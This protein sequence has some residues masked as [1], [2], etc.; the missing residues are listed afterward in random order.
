[1]TSSTKDAWCTQSTLFT[2]ETA[3][4]LVLTVLPKSEEACD[5][6]EPYE[7]VWPVRHTCGTVKEKSKSFENKNF[8]L[9]KVI[10]KSEK[11]HHLN[12]TIDDPPILRHCQ[13]SVIKR[14]QPTSGS[15]PLPVSEKSVKRRQTT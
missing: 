9:K 13:K 1:M 5:I 3:L 4:S 11:C 10:F 2:A 15:F 7:S 8:A 14:R 12:K 6:F